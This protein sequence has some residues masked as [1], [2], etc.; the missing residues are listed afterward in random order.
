MRLE[1]ANRGREGFTNKI[2]T[3][4]PDRLGMTRE[5]SRIMTLRMQVVTV[6][7]SS[8]VQGIEF[9]ICLSEVTCPMA[10]LSGALPDADF[11]QVFKILTHGLA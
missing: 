4:S 2:R 11:N 10:S 6:L 1:S 3:R 5:L 9:D 8:R 7:L